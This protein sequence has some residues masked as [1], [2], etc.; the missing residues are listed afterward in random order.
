MALAKSVKIKFVDNKF[1][2]VWS[3]AINLLNL[4]SLNFENENSF[5]KKDT[6][7]N[8]KNLS[9]SSCFSK[10]ASQINLT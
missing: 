1:K 4:I 7:I 10:F 2:L 6:K 8:F 5:A 3:L 9:S